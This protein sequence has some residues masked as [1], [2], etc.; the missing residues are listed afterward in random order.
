MAF[1]AVGSAPAV[2]LLPPLQ[3]NLVK[4]SVGRS[5]YLAQ[6]GGNYDI[7]CS[8]GRILVPIWKILTKEEEII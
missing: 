7:S 3:F 6:M 1:L 2:P 4:V 5:R 8:N